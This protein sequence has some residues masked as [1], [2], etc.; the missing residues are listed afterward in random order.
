MPAV[1]PHLPAA[2]LVGSVAAFAP[3]HLSESTRRTRPQCSLVA[4]VVVVVGTATLLGCPVLRQLSTV[5][6]A[7]ASDSP[8]HC[9]KV[10]LFVACSAEPD[11]RFA[12]QRIRRLSVLKVVARLYRL[13][14]RKGYL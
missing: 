8:L 13:T 5:A 6:A 9:Q 10:L 2:L 1:K 4:V 12:Y 11:L 3:G 14:H 7:A